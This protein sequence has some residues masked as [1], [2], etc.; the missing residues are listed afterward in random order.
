M[1]PPHGQRIEHEK[2]SPPPTASKAQTQSRSAVTTRYNDS[3]AAAA[4][5]WREPIVQTKPAAAWGA[6]CMSETDE[7]P[8][9]FDP[10]LYVAHP[11]NTDLGGLG[12]DQ[13][14]HHY[15]LYGRAEGRYCSAVDGRE[16][17]LALIPTGGTV[18]YIDPFFAPGVELPNRTVRRL[19]ARTTDE[20]REAA[21]QAAIDPAAVPEIDL[22]WHGE[23]YRELTRERFDAV[24][25]LHSLERQPCLITH[26]SDVASVLK[27]GARYFLAIADRRFGAAHYLPDSLLPDALE[28]FAVRRTRHVARNVI[29]NRLMATHDNAAA[30][31]AGIHGPDP[32]RR[33]ADNPLRQESAALLRSL[34]SGTPD[35]VTPAWYFTPES[36]QYLIDTL[37]VLGLSPLR[38]ERLYWTINPF[39]AFYCVLR[40]AA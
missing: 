13:A 19:A 37:A 29:A 21:R 35:A 20:L 39:S 36:F 8:P 6:G 17:F 7:L 4:G 11:A 27:P 5:G 25:G 9:E 3:V 28:A 34:R 2:V 23:P 32:R 33:E 22:V 24:L 15:D 26:L 18:L 30:H 38:I 12:A 16:A 31:W 40:V 10:A 1:K 14:R